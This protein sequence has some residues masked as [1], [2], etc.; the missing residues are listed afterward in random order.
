MKLYEGIIERDNVEYGIV[1]A[2][3]FSIHT[4][5]KTILPTDDLPDAKIIYS[6]ESNID[7]ISYFRTITNGTWVVCSFLDD[8]MQHPVI[9]G[10]VTKTVNQLPNFDDGF[11][12]ENGEYPSKTGTTIS[13]EAITNY[14]YNR[15]IKTKKHLIEIDDT[16]GTERINIK[17]SSGATILFD[18]TGQITLTGVD[19]ININ[20]SDDFAVAYTDLKVAFDQLVTDF[21]NAVT[22]FNAHTH[23]SSGAGTPNPPTQIPSTSDMSAAKVETVKL[24]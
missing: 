19:N 20:G 1:K 14:P 9:L 3:I 11:T 5:D 10:S 22:V 13:T 18:Q 16:E 6:A 17:H 12:D 21:N 7:E 4:H 2:R 8:S 15:V 23:S 24:P